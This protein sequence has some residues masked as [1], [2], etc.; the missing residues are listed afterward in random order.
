MTEIREESPHR[1]ILPKPLPIFPG[2]EY[3]QPF[4]I[5]G[6]ENH[7]F[8]GFTASVDFQ[9]HFLFIHGLQDELPLDAADC[10]SHF[11]KPLLRNIAR[12]PWSDPDP[13]GF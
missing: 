8:G 10:Y 13:L 9:R 6:I 11:L 3:F 2:L 7:P 5:L 4:F 1:L 12:G